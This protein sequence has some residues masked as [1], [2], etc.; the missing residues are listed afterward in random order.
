V[1]VDDDADRTLM[2]DFI[3]SVGIRLRVGSIEVT[4]VGTKA[5][6][7]TVQDHSDMETVHQRNRDKLVFIMG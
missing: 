3:G 6:T 5:V 4:I 2:V 7:M 1:E